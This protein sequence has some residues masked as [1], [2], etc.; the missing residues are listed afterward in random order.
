VDGWRPGV[1]LEFRLLPLPTHRDRRASPTTSRETQVT[2]AERDVPGPYLSENYWG[3]VREN[4]SEDANAWVYFSH[5]QARSHAYRW[6]ED[7][8][9]GVS[10]DR[11]QL[12]KLTLFSEAVAAERESMEVTGA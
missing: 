7:G 5:D 2:R 6:G 3:T 1:F 11:Q 9:A 10:N 8:L 4:Y 12:G